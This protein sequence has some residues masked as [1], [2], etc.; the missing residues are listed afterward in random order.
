MSEKNIYYPGANDG[1]LRPKSLQVNDKSD[2]AKDLKVAPFKKEIRKTLPHKHHNYFEII[3]LSAGKGIHTIDSQAYEIKPPTIFV[4]RKEQVHHWELESE[5]EGYVLILKKSFVDNSVDKDLKNLLSRVSA[6]SCMLL[7]QNDAIAQLFSMLVKENEAALNTNNAIVE[8]LLKVL[9]GKILQL[10]LP[11]ERPAG[12][13]SNLYLQFR[14]LLGQA[15]EIKNNVSH[16]ARLLNTSPQN[17]N[18]SCRK[19]A[20]QSAAELLSEYIINESRRL[21]LYTNMTVAEISHHLDFKD[22]SHYIKYFKRH[23]GHT[24]QAFRML[25]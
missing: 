17:L 6:L 2:S 4:I 23:T 1:V 13:S 25:A 16:Y 10:S 21:L 15:T 24:P 22:S 19:A 8:G 3:F 7:Q 20:N 5:P 11:A 12:R 18:A 9:L 14:D